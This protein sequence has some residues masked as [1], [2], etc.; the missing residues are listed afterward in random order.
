MV[1]A[2]LAISILALLL[3]GLV[4]LALMELMTD[5]P[6]GPQEPSED[7]VEEFELPTGVEGTAASSHG[8]PELLDQAP[9][10][11]VLV[12]SPVCAT[13][14][15][16]AASF[17]GELPDGLTVLVTAADPVR[18]RKWAAAQGLP[19]DELV[20]DDDMSVVNG[21][22]ISSSPAE[23]G[24]YNGRVAFAAHVG[25]RRAID[26]L[27]IQRVIPDVEGTPG[28]EGLDSTTVEAQD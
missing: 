28:V 16:L 8:L 6:S 20:F 4:A 9:T 11:L 17:E 15:Q 19:I 25:G 1:V 24:T 21:L 5:R 23:V 2:A 12:V 3:C 10:H 7:L 18:M 13:C 14:Q 26:N 27:L 22:G